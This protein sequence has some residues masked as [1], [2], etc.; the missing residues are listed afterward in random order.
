MSNVEAIQEASSLLEALDA[1]GV[2]ND[3]SNISA[4]DKMAAIGLNQD[5]T[6]RGRHRSMVKLNGQ[7]IAERVA[8]YDRKGQVHMVPT[9]QLAYFLSKP[10]AERPS[11]KAFYARKPADAQEPK[12]IEESCDIC[13]ENSDGNV[14]KKFPS[15]RQRTAHMRDRHPDEWDDERESKRSILGLLADMSAEDKAALKGVLGV[16]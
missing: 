12:Y 10:H 2:F 15:Q 7:E 6:R 1:N 5:G 13:F 8:V 14:V 4:A 3:G 11:Q 9:V 16:K